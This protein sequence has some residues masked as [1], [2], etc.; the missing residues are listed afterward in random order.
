MTEDPSNKPSF[1]M[2][3]PARR[4]DLIPGIRK[5]ELGPLLS[6]PLLSSASGLSHCHF[7]TATQLASTPV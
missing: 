4:Y 2:A 5:K 7:Q 1:Q 6:T 3:F